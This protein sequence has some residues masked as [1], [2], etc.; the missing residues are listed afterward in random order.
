MIGGFIALWC[1]YGISKCCQDTSQSLAKQKKTRKE[2]SQARLALAKQPPHGFRLP[3][4]LEVYKKLHGNTLNLPAVDPILPIIVRRSKKSSL[5]SNKELLQNNSPV[6]CADTVY[7]ESCHAATNFLIPDYAFGDGF[8]GRGA[9]A[10]G[11]FVGSRAGTVLD[12]AVA[13]NVA[14]TVRQIL[15]HN[16]TPSDANSTAPVLSAPTSILHSSSSSSIVLSSL[17]S[18]EM[19]EVEYEVYSQTMEQEG[20]HINNND[21]SYF[22]SE[23]IENFVA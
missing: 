3:G 9:Y 7:P 11:E 1:M 6:T 4:R 14:A 20:S 12:G 18:S 8:N 19:S 21:I 5:V 15:A 23:E 13:N 10:E 2:L 16:T 22:S 17:H